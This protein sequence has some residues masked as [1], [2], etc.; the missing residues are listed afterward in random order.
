MGIG[1]AYLLVFITRYSL[2]MLCV[3]SVSVLLLVLF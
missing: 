1:I 2:C 3:G